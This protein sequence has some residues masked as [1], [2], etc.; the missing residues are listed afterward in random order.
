MMN[1]LVL[2][3]FAAVT[4]PV[5][6]DAALV[7]DRFLDI[8]ILG[9]SDVPLLVT[10]RTFLGP[11]VNVEVKSVDGQRIGYLGPRAT[12]TVPNVC[13]FSLLQKDE[14][15]GRRIDLRAPW[16][17]SLVGGGQAPL[18]DGQRYE[19]TVTYE[20]PEAVHL[21]KQAR[22]ELS[23]KWHKFAEL[24]GEVQAKPIRVQ[25]AAGP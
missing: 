9:Q 13:E 11:Y 5:S 10:R 3:L 17:V 2:A 4:P 19:L 25:L 15:F 6:V 14:F 24:S 20:D 22:S 1:L 21:S 7:E 23:R 18:A 8:R 12:V 16:V